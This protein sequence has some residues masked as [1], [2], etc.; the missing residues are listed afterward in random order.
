MAERVVPALIPDIHPP[1]TEHRRGRSTAAPELAQVPSAPAEAT[2]SY[3]IARV[4]RS[5]RVSEQSIV[6]ELGWTADDALDL[7][8]IGAS[9]GTYRRAATGWYRL[10]ARREIR[11]PAPMRARCGITPGDRLLLAASGVHDALVIY[12]MPE[13][14][15]LLSPHHEA[16]LQGGRS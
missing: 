3:A 12:T 11:L 16:N 8:T 6:N 10:T 4:D 14:D 7:T 15:R 2:W 9:L 1:A 13:L 5:G